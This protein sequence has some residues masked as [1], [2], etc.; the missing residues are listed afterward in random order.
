VPVCIWTRVIPCHMCIWDMLSTLIA[1]TRHLHIHLLFLALW[2]SKEGWGTA[3][4]GD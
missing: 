4:V 1:V 3:H 2:G